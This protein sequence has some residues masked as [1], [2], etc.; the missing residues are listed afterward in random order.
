VHQVATIASELVDL[1]ATSSA[2]IGGQSRFAFG[3][4]RIAATSW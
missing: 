1:L 4:H 3:E 2:A